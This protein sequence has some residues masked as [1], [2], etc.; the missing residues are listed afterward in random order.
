MKKQA[1][2][3]ELAAVVFCEEDFCAYVVHLQN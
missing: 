2:R 1:E 3:A